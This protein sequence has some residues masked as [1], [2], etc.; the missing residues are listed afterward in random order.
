MRFTKM[1]GLG[2][3]FV[4]MEQKQ[5]PEHVSELAKEICH[6]RTGVGADG[7]VFLLP[8]EEANFRMRIFNADGS[9]A[10]QCG[11]ALRCVAKY[12]FERIDNRSD[13][14]TIETK[15]GIQPVKL[16]VEDGIVE[17]VRVDMGEPIL[18]AAKVPVISNK[19]QVV[20]ETISVEDQAFAITAVS[21]GNPHAVIEV[22]DV[23]NYPVRKW[24]P[25]LENHPAFPERANIEFVT[26]H[27]PHEITMRV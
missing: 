4:M 2:N 5:V 9:E 7:L 16:S 18:E 22:E 11:N 15:R 3:D 21:M 6:R 1:H 13:Q 20:Q 14:I 10:Q 26:F 8:S 27:S 23:P 17:Q 25:Q 19:Q 12:Y 24:G